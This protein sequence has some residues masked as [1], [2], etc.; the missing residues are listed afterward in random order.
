MQREGICVVAQAKYEKDSVAHRKRTPDGGPCISTRRCGSKGLWE[1]VGYVFGEIDIIYKLVRPPEL[2][3]WSYNVAL[4]PA[5]HDSIFRVRLPRGTSCVATQLFEE[6]EKVL[7]DIVD[8]EVVVRLSPS[9]QP[10]FAYRQPQGGV[11][12]RSYFLPRNRPWT[13]A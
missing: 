5:S 6:Q 7:K 9:L 11:V 8:D 1:Y 2:Q 3:R 10:E 13:C 4:Q 12:V